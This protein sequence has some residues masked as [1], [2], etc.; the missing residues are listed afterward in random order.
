MLSAICFNLDQS[1]ILLSDNA[2]SRFFKQKGSLTYLNKKLHHIQF[3]DDKSEG[4]EIKL[5]SFEG[6]K[7]IAGQRENI[8][9]HH[10]LP[11]HNVY[12]SLLLQDHNNQDHKTKIIIDNSQSQK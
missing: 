3:A 5:K 9:C 6:M 10:F 11:C 8:V 12:K 4:S 2:L 1:K 7:N